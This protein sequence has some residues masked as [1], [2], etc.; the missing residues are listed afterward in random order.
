[1]STLATWFAAG[2][3]QADREGRESSE[4]HSLLP[5]L[6]AVPVPSPGAPARYARTSGSGPGG[7]SV[8]RDTPAPAGP[9]RAGGHQVT[10]EAHMPKGSIQ[11]GRRGACRVGPGHRRVAQRVEGT[12]N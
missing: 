9:L 7:S 3:T 2:A 10:G 11:R 5:V 8:V 12:W 1:M 4:S 6:G